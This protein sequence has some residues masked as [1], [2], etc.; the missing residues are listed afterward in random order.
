MLTIDVDPLCLL[1]QESTESGDVTFDL[2]P[3][4][5]MPSSIEETEL[6]TAPPATATT[7]PDVSN[8]VA[9]KP[10]VD[11][12]AYAHVQKVNVHKV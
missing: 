2:N 10:T 4:A 12:S 8:H 9:G 3:P 1:V 5:D 7:Q 6:A 11:L